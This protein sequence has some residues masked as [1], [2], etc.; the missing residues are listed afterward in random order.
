MKEGAKSQINCIKSF[1]HYMLVGCV[2]LSNWA[3]LYD[4]GRIK[5]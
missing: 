5:R 1:I 2:Q 3:L 4:V